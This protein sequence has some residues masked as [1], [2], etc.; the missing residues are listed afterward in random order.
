MP[1][2]RTVEDDQILVA[3]AQAVGEVGPGGLTLAQV[4]EK[5][6]LSPATLVQRFGSKRGL[7]LALAVHDADA[8][9][10]RIRSAAQA[11]E[12]LTALVEVL[13]GFASSI[14]SARSFANHL[15]FLLMDL[16][17]PDFQEV[18]RRHATAI[19]QATAEVLAAAVDRGTANLHLPVTETARLVHTVYSG[20]LVTWGMDPRGS[21]RS[22]VSSALSAVLGSLT[23]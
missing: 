17:D 1:R 14:G 4:G 9:P 6:G 2:P 5:V 8:M 20:A 10:S 13:A 7:L 21:A 19:Q 3:A 11:E 16:S 23:R 22:A 18:S 15:S 12:P